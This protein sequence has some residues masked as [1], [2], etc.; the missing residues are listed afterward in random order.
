MKHPAMSLSDLEFLRRARIEN[1]AKRREA[2]RLADAA[3][4][5]GAPLP[6]PTTRPPRQHDPK[7]PECVCDRCD[8]DEAP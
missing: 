6:L 2:R 1:A 7:D 4:V 5:N 8:P 3:P